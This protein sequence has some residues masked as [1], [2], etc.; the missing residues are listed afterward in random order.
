M[1]HFQGTAFHKIY[2]PNPAFTNTKA[3]LCPSWRVNRSA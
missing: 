2:G 3:E 1:P